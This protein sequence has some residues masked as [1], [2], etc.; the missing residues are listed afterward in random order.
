M[1][2]RTS[3][4]NRRGLKQFVTFSFLI[5]AV[6]PLLLMGALFSRIVSVR[7]NDE[8]SAKNE[9][10]ANT[11]QMNIENFLN[12]N[13]YAMNHLK[14]LLSDVQIED[15]DRLKS[16]LSSYYQIYPYFESLQIVDTD[17]FVRYTWPMNPNIVGC[18]CFAPGLLPAGD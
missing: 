8:I 10:I 16:L 12:E 11:L 5:V 17:G 9:L 3:K 6:L 15:H 13:S 4:N 7:F 18:G 14:A 2:W 1:A